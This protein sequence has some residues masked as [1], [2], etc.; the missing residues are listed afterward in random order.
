MGKCDAYLTEKAIT[1]DPSQGDSCVRI[2]RQIFQNFHNYAQG[3]EE[4][5]VTV[6]TD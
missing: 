5:C 4:E 1:R 3:H 2:K 6:M